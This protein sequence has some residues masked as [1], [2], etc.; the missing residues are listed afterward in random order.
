MK[1]KNRKLRKKPGMDYNNRINVVIAIIFLL[2]LAVVYRLYYLQVANH[3]LYIAL[4]SSQHQVL[5]KLE[6]ERGKIFIQDRG[7][8][9]ERD[10]YPI[11]TNKEFA[12]IFAVPKDI[13]NPEEAADK[14]Y[15]ILFRED[16]EKEVEEML[17]DEKRD[18]IINELDSLVGLSEEEI[19][20]KKVELENNQKSLLS[21]EEY[22]EFLNIKREA[23]ISLKKNEIVDEFKNKFSKKNDPYEPI[24]DKVDEEGLGKV[25]E[26][27]IPGISYL[28]QKH[29]YYPEDFSSHISGFYG[30]S[31]DEKKGLYGLEGFFDVELSGKAGLIKAERDA[32]GNVIIVNDMEYD[33]EQNGSDLVLTIDRTIQFTAC[34]KLKESAERHGAD[35]GSVIVMRPQ[36]GEIVAMCS[37][38]DYDPNNYREAENSEVYNNQ[39]IFGQYE[40]GS[41]FK[42]ITMAAGLDTGAITPKTI[43]EDKG[44]IMIEGWPKPIK[45]SDFSTHGAWGW[46]DM[47]S[48]LENSLNTGVIFAMEKTGDK[49]FT[50]YVKDFGFG[51]KEGIELETEAPGDISNLL[52]K[53]IRPVDSAVASFGQ[54]ITATPLQLINSYAAIA[55]GGK[56]MKPY[57]VAEMIDSNGTKSV[58]QARELKRVISEKTALIL[59][60]ML[61]NV[62]DG[63]HAKLAAVDGYYVAGKTGTAQ[64]ADDVTKGY[65]EKTIHTFVGF[66]PVEEPEFVMLVRLDDPKDVYYSASSAAPLFGDIAE[67]ILNYWKIPKERLR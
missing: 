52:R 66:S 44:S 22:A 5:N 21:D 37:Y 53:T 36:T 16:V 59:S 34:T 7:D 13:E 3:D 6:P 64:V 23:N 18:E 35:A 19:L 51:E 58:T 57:L 38:P 65:G 12:H 55:N 17:N 4:A 42:T 25:L 43:Y 47:S 14:I 8:G 10:L 45:N 39:A 32:Q 15:E 61:V 31:S 40:P 49:I 27:N 48:V 62:V 41:V 20:S 26:Q 29:R 54:G 67:F 56:L 28:M 2:W 30:Y 1:F 9:E 33:K 24:K 60:G 11:A 63:G 46:A 50:Q